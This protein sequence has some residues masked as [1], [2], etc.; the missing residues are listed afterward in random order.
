[1][2]SR[3]KKALGQHFLTDPRILA[4]IADQLEAAPGEVV[5][6]IGPGRGALTGELARRGL[7]VIAIE[8]DT[9]LV[10][11]LVGRWPNVRVV[12]GDALALDWRATA[13]V[14]SGQR[15][16][17]IGNIPYNI[18]SPLIE[19]A[20]D[21]APASIVLLIQKEVAQRLGALPGTAQYGALTVG[22]GARA[23]I[24]V[25]FSVPA[26]AFHPRPKVDSAVVRLRPISEAVTDPRFRRLVVGLF[27]ARR[28]QLGRALRT[29]LGVEP[30]VAARLL[31]RAGLDATERPET[32]DVAA[33]RRLFA[34]IVDEGRAAP[35]TL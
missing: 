22:V 4:R 6:E 35:L 32:L 15:W 17:V 10:P 30:P 23:K 1:M 27:G 18:T 19:R 12:E 31:D 14:V 11:A 2:I 34:A 13:G 16:F 25:A 20:I 9:T 29:V 3:P 5:L 24:E 28:K 7:A 33:F 21:A 8:R 26:G